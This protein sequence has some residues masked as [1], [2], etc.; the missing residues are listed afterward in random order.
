MCTRKQP[1]NV[2]SYLERHTNSQYIYRIQ[3]KEKETSGHATLWC[4]LATNTKHACCFFLYGSHLQTDTIS[5]F[6]WEMLS[7][8]LQAYVEVI[9]SLKFFF[10]KV[11]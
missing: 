8:H 9:Q 6:S 4:H 2:Y 3:K 7:H 10:V 11:F 1:S 5:K